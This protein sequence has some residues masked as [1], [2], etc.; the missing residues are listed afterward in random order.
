MGLVMPVRTIRGA[1]GIVA[2]DL[3]ATTE[4]G[5]ASQR[6]AIRTGVVPERSWSLPA[7]LPGSRMR[8]GGSLAAAPFCRGL[9]VRWSGGWSGSCRRQS[10]AELCFSV[11]TLPRGKAGACIAWQGGLWEPRSGREEALPALPSAGK[12]GPRLWARADSGP[13][14]QAE[15]S[16][17]LLP[18]PVELASSRG[19]PG[20]RPQS[21]SPQA[22]GARAAA[23]PNASCLSA[24]PFSSGAALIGRAAAEPLGKAASHW[25][26]PRVCSRRSGPPAT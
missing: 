18:S 16:G 1:K 19:V 12:Q 17:K 26:R 24:R 6:L 5:Q 4:R 7:P 25:S 11:P 23:R 21:C 9:N 14:P 20:L 2:C 3:S 10:A 15:A 8:P 13:G 22:S